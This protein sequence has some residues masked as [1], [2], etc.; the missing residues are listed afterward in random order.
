[1]AAGANLA[2]P[3]AAVELNQPQCHHTAV[4][5]GASAEKG[6]GRDGCVAGKGSQQQQQFGAAAEALC[7]ALTGILPSP[8]NS[9]DNLPQA[10]RVHTEEEGGTHGSAGLPR[11]TGPC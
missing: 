7:A 4:P 10:A 8:T 3:T 5:E 6:A 2:A 1:M 11:D 9:C